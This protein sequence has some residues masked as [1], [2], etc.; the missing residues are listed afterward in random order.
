MPRNENAP[1]VIQTVLQVYQEVGIH[2]FPLDLKPILKHYGI[3]LRT[4]E[5][6][7]KMLGCS[8]EECIRAFGADAISIEQDGRCLIL[9]NSRRTPKDRIRFTIGHELGH[10]LLEH[11]REY[12]SSTLRRSN[13]DDEEYKTLE[14][15]A[16]HFAGYLLS[17]ATVVR[18]LLRDYGY[19]SVYDEYIGRTTLV[20]Y[21]RAKE[22]PDKT[23]P[24]T[25]LMAAFRI[26]KAAAVTRLAKL[27]EDLRQTRMDTAQQVF[28]NMKHKAQYRCRNC[29]A[30]KLPKARACY[31]CGSRNKFDYY[32]ADEPVKVPHPLPYR[33]ERF[34]SCPFCGNEDIRPD[35][36]NCI[37]CGKILANPCLPDHSRNRNAQTHLNPPECRFCT[38]CGATTWYQET[39]KI[40]DVFQYLTVRGRKK[41][42]EKGEIVTV[43]Y[44]PNIPYDE[45]TYRAYR[46]P[47]CL[48]ELNEEDAK[49][50]II[51]GLDLQ[52]LCEGEWYDNEHYNQHANP[53]HARFCR[54]C[55]KPT[56]NGSL[57]I[58]PRYQDILAQRD[59]DELEDELR[60]MDLDTELFMEMNTITE[61]KPVVTAPY[62]E[63]E[64]DGELPF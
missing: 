18:D 5:E 22:L 62:E 37:I 17:P 24:E 49:Y 51:C 43:K 31:L 21:D 45:D 9:Y 27:R 46:C 56:A 34:T 44:G 8:I 57:K 36:E 16:D 19:T 60:Q 64:D 55:G 30:R 39:D 4:Y 35:D 23:T 6:H 13:T 54:T 41:L 2:E 47:R 63:L 28:D 1:R 26:T 40:Q 10:Y 48:N 52:N 32:A 33:N 53:P 20:R 42:E 50:C 12:G 25:L 29:G 7:C 58:L 14:R 15:E 59:K 11:H 61:E 38:S 3:R